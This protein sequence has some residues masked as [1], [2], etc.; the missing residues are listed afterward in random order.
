MATLGHK[1]DA[2][3]LALWRMDEASGNLVDAVGAYPLTL[4]GAPT[5]VAGK[6]GNA[7]Q[8]AAQGDCFQSAV[9][10]AGDSTTFSSGNYTVEVW[11]NIDP[12]ITGTTAWPGYGTGGRTGG[13]LFSVQSVGLW[14]LFFILDDTGTLDVK[15]STGAGANTFRASGPSWTS[16]AT[17]TWHHAAVRRTVVD[18]S[19]GLYDIFLDG[20]KK[21]STTL[22]APTDSGASNRF[23]VG[24]IDVAF[25]QFKGQMDD[26]RL[27][28]IARSDAEISESFWRGI[29]D[30]SRPISPRF[31]QLTSQAWQAYLQ[32]LAT[33]QMQQ[34]VGAAIN[35]AFASQLDYAADRL[36][37]A[38]KAKFPGLAPPDAL[39]Q[40]G[41]ERGMPQG[42]SESNAAYA[43]RLLD[44]WNA[45]PWAG[46]AFGLLR[47]FYS[48]GYTNVVIGQPNGGQVFTLD[49][50]GTNLLTWSGDFSNTAWTKTNVTAAINNSAAPDGTTTAALLTATANAG[51]VEQQGIASAAATQYTV[52][53]YCKLSGGAHSG[54]LVLW[55]TTAGSAIAT[56]GLVALTSS[57]VRLSVSGLGVAGHALRWR[58]Y[59]A[60]NQAATGAA[61]VAYPQFEIAPAP[62]PYVQ[63]YSVNYPTS[64][65][66]GNM[67]TTTESNGIWQNAPLS[68]PYTAPYKQTFWSQFDVVFPL[69][70]NPATFSWS[71]GVPA[72]NSAESNFIRALIAAWKPAHATCKSIV[73]VTAGQVFGFP[74]T[75]LWGSGNGL[76]GG[77]TTTVWAP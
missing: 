45:W 62:T 16:L 34:P 71:G 58:F 23:T 51:F 52:S 40:I 17:G 55:D 3:T 27:S 44:A 29:L 1:L 63:T 30:T 22:A 66:A 59:P 37:M 42:Q 36:R 8:F 64:I 15:I 6:I 47:A 73:I 12:S 67:V 54:E 26:V 5:V 10:A 21:T 4:V 65:G 41:A 75:R 46:T 57:F 28:G 61:L 76:W 39:T 48:T 33:T 50:G 25:D 24:A 68:S 32:Q 19:H 74:A 7:R 18:A 69:P 2:N 38:L 49:Q 72:S 35:M 53:A 70:L 31:Q 11:F 60:G 9:I 56:T 13:A 77:N 43:A 14:L 20:A